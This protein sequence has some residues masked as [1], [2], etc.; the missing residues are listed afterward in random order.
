M[1]TIAQIRERFPSAKNLTDGQ[2]VDKLAQ[3]TQTPFE[4]VAGR[5]GMYEDTPRGMLGATNDYMI[6]AANSAAGLVSS[7]GNMVSPGN[8]VSSFIEDEFI[9]PGEARQSV[10]VQLAKR[11]LG[12]ALSTD[13][14]GPQAS[15]VWDYVTENPALAASQAVGSFAPLGLGIKGVQFGTAAL[16]TRAGLD[17]AKTATLASRAG[18]GAG[19]VLSGAASGGDAA[20]SAYDLVKETPWETLSQHPQAQALLAQ[21]RSQDEIYEELATRA[22]RRASVV[23]AMI[24]AVAGA[25]GAE[26]ALTS[27]VRGLAGAGKTVLKEFGGEA[28]E[29]G[30]TQYF[31]QAEAAEYNPTINPMDG[32]VGAGLLGG[33]LGAGVAAPIALANMQNYDLTQRG[34]TPPPAEPLAGNAPVAPPI[35]PPPPATT[36]PLGNVPKLDSWTDTNLKATYD[37]QMSK[38]AE[39]RNMP[40]LQAVLDEMDFRT[41]TNKVVPDEPVSP[42]PLT[43]LRPNLGLPT[44]EDLA[45]DQAANPQLYGPSLQQPVAPTTTADGTPIGLTDVPTAPAQPQGPPTD[46]V[47][48][49]ADTFGIA[50]AQGVNEAWDVMG[51]RVYGQQQLNNLVNELTALVAQQPPQM[52]DLTRALIQSGAVRIASGQVPTAK[53][54]QGAVTSALK[55]LQLEGVSDVNRAG[56]ILNDQI[57]TLVEQ[58]KDEGDVKLGQL[59]MT[60]ENLFGTPAPA[61]AALDSA[62]VGSV[63]DSLVVSSDGVSQPA[64]SPAPASAGAGLSTPKAPK[65]NGTQTPQTKQAKAQGQAPIAGIPTDRTTTVGRKGREVTVNPQQLLQKIAA[66]TPMEKQRILDAAGLEVDTDPTTGAPR[67]LQTGEPRTMADV[68]AMETERTGVTITADGVRQS[69]AKFGITPAVLDQVAGAGMDTVSNAELGLD[70][71]G[72]DTGFRVSE[73]LSK[74]TNEG[75][76]QGENE[77]K[78][79]RE[80]REAAD[81]LLEK[82]GPSTAVANIDERPNAPAG[83]KVTDLRDGNQARVN[84]N[85]RAALASPD[86]ESAA[87]EWDGNM[88]DRVIEA[89]EQG[90]TLADVRFDSLP[91]TLK[92]DWILG[93]MENKQSNDGELDLQELERLQGDLLND[94]NTIQARTRS[95]PKGIAGP[96]KRKADQPRNEPT[97][98]GSR[99]RVG[100]TG[101]VT[102]AQ[103]I[104]RTAEEQYTRLV[105]QAREQ[106]AQ[107]SANAELSALDDKIDMYKRLLS[108]IA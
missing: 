69:L 7:I 93:Y 95:N 76:V 101:E 104:I 35:A 17:A 34:Q 103:E 99:S 50:P 94:Y 47:Q 54:I 102:D 89:E 106:V 10:P 56:E 87:A 59:A 18:L 32:V 13:E 42:P 60:Y 30:S 97:D 90:D 20:G 37:Y 98:K 91:D 79:Q 33:T 36:Q 31:G 45:A 107:Q 52:Q 51:G 82:A 26:K 27:G 108:C 16:G 105:E 73:S 66:A 86:L 21:N 39:T 65:T 71:E 11:K 28:L 81:K 6:E 23:P 40:L 15:G 64:G 57:A 22:A 5:F 62:G 85:I 1:P 68:A 2:I 44:A 61:T 77:T 83:A 9:K 72:T 4:E 67:I 78:K 75:L 70:V 29:E 74:V 43:P 19:S 49:V 80:A 53:K 25:T 3:L 8:R 41:E 38:P 58:G 12:R 88:T 55:R 46:L 48:Q 84:E 92:A 63:S 96:E 100:K 14:I 24:G